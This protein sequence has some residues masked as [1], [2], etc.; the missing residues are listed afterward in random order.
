MGEIDILALLT[1]DNPAARKIDL[2]IYADALRVYVEGAKN[3]L[4]NGAVCAHPRTGAPLENPYLKIVAQQG[5][6]LTKMRQIKSDSLIAML[7][8]QG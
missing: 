3:V 6:I 7:M 5:A 2:Q 8:A 4:A 1:A